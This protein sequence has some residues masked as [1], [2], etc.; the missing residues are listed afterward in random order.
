MADALPIARYLLRLAAQE[1]EP[2]PIT[3]MRLHKLMYYVQGWSLTERGEPMFP[4]RIEAWTHGP[5]V[6][7]LYPVYR[8]HENQAIPPGEADEAGLAE[9]DRAFVRSIW[10]R[11]KRF[12]ATELRRRTH[13]ET[14][15]LTARDGLS[16]DASSKREISHESMRSFFEQQRARDRWP[17]FDDQLLDEAEQAFRAGRGVPLNRIARSA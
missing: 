10:E 16:D 14:P 12:S 9:P 7:T 17:D 2:E 4:D 8:D 5:V 6:P 13:A 1:P 3:Q 11:Y 15:W